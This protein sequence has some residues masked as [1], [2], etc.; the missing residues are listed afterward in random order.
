MLEHGPLTYRKRDGWA[1][2]RNPIEILVRDGEDLDVV[3]RGVLGD[4][5]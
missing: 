5:L 2:L 4:E 1:D 3:L